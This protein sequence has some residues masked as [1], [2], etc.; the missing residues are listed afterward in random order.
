M[1]MPP[2]KWNYSLDTETDRIIN[3][4]HHT[5]NR[6]FTKAGF[7]VLPYPI[8]GNGQSVYLPDLN[9]SFS[10]LKKCAQ[11]PPLIPMPAAPMVVKLLKKQLLAWGWQSEEAAVNQFKKNW[12]KTAPQFWTYFNH[13]FPHLKLQKLLIQ[14]T[15]FGSLSSFDLKDDQLS[16]YVR[17]DMNLGH[18]AEA[19]VSGAL[20]HRLSNRGR[21]YNWSEKEA[22]VDI[23]LTQSSFAQLFPE[24]SPTLSLINQKENARLSL[25]NQKYQQKLGINNQSLFDIKNDQLIIMAKPVKNTFSEV[26][27]KLLKTLIQRKNQLC[28]F[29][30]LAEVIWPNES[31]KKFS[32]WAIAKTIQ[33]LRDKLELLGINPA[34]IQTRRKQGYMLVD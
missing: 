27:Q 31:E 14:P 32:Y 26:E 28:S 12:Q 17:L 21:G 2:T 15:S 23:L 9:Y 25:E 34:V 30:S 4:L 5:V 7:L 13:F 10:L 29:D 16:V 8:P 20:M 1:K 11:M 22:F 19:V 24:Y 18:L 3:T 33:R 6:F